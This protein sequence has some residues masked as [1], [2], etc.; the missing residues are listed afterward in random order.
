MLSLHTNIASMRIQGALGN[1][2]QNLTTSMT[3]LGTGYRINSASDDAAGLQI[4]TRLLSQ[5]RGMQMASQ[6]ASNATS[7]LQTAEGA[8]AEVENILHRMKD[9]ATQ[10]ADSAW[11][12]EDRLSLQKEY[13]ALGTELKN[14]IDGTSYG[15]EKLFASASGASGAAGKLTKELTFQIGNTSGET[16]KLDVSTALK[17]VVDAFGEASQ[18]FKGASGAS[19]FTDITT[20]SGANKLLD[21]LSTAL[22]SVGGIRAEIGAG[23]NRLSHITANLSNMTNNTKDA[24]GQIRDVDYASETANMTK[25]NILQQAGGSM[26]KQASQMSQ[27]V[28]SLLQ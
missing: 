5:S 15:G 10:A 22:S 28:L 27:L 21:S 13:D 14:I 23:Q 2:Q 4:A 12:E 7:M 18:V 26:L 3:R 19:G 24:E 25:L 16:M 9:L 8:F 20:A 6:N 11:T 17:N 1:T